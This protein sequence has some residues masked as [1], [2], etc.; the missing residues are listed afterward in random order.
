MSQ[1]SPAS[2]VGRDRRETSGPLRHMAASPHFGCGRD[3]RPGGA[4]SPRDPVAPARGRES[5]PLPGLRHPRPR[6]PRRRP[7]PARPS[8]PRP[9]LGPESP[10]RD[11]RPR[12]PER[13]LPPR[14][15]PRG[16][17][18]RTAFLSRPPCDS[19]P[20]R[21]G[22]AGGR[23]AERPNRPAAGPGARGML[24]SAVPHA[25]CVLRRRA[26]GLHFPGGRAREAPPSPGDSGP[27]TREA[28]TGARVR[29]LD[30]PPERGGLSKSS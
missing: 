26:R 4:A 2:E 1:D 12:D 28:A 29:V 17:P 5:R 16:V 14:P 27:R 21:T 6:D 13:R 24:G 7:R 18:R 20:H 22:R 23:G 3:R 30:P 25:A 8:G 9:A 15:T 19:S 10:G 11:P